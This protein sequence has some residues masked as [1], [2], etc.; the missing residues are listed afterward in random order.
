MKTRAFVSLIYGLIVI[1]YGVM[2][3]SY[4]Y[5]L[6]SVLIEIPTGIIILINVYFLMKEKKMALYVLL[7]LSFLLSI[8]YGYNFSKT[9]HFFPALLTTVS[10]FVFM[11]EVLRIFRVFGAD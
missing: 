4:E 8:Y 2:G 11:D 5:S 3:Y 7:V 6:A 10:F 9:T 1:F